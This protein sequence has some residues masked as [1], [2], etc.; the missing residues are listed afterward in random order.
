MVSVFIHYKTIRVQATVRNSENM[1]L[2]FS[3]WNQ[4]FKMA[5]KQEDCLYNLFS[6][7]LQQQ[8]PQNLFVYG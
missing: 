7:L 1:M 6:V 8:L 3:W 5:W 4:G 2:N